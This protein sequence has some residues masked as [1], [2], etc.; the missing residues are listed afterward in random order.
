[1]SMEQGIVVSGRRRPL[2]RWL[3]TAAMLQGALT[4]GGA[5]ATEGGGN[6]YPVGVETN[7]NGL[8]FPEG[9]HPCLYYSHYEATD[10]KD[11]NGNDNKQLA[12][13][14][15]QSDIVALRL[16]YVW[17]GVRVFGAQL[18]TRVVQAVAAV[19]LD[20]AI[21]RPNGAAPLDRSGSKTGLADTALTPFILGWHGTSYHQTAGVDTHLK[22]GS[23]HVTDR[24][25][26]GRNYYQVAP[27][28]AFTWFPLASL[29]LNGK[30]RYAF[31]S[32]NKDTN[33]Q[34]GDEATFEFSA[35][36][37]ATPALVVGV[38]GYVYRQTSDDT[39]N[40]LPVN[41]N[42]NRGKVNALGPYF[43][44]NFTP[45]TSLIV[46]VQS[47]FGARNRPQGTRVWAQIR[48]PL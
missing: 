7:Y 41:G 17:P 12:R 4:G 30:L 16:T 24:I 3:Q 9:L 13:F 36:Y 22:L 11:N 33:Y 48:M 1:M 19:D 45:K 31:N 23:Y 5:L 38:N 46:K 43:T 15:L 26:T 25:N 8:M 40:G 18:E 39:L 2:R 10:N 28:Y 20:L 21:A 29:D 34:S 27:F 47:E 6:S 42:G 32:R 14:R 37:R 35:G 44:Y